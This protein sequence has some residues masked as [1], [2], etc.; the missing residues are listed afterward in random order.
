[1]ARTRLFRGWTALATKALAALLLLQL[2]FAGPG[3]VAA[4]GQGW[5]VCHV[6]RSGGAPAP[7]QAPHLCAFCPCLHIVEAAPPAL[8]SADA[9]LPFAE[10]AASRPPSATAPLTPAGRAGAWSSR[11]P[12]HA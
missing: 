12:P 3:A 6:E 5:S 7:S 2:A 8:G 11:A 1:M 10:I 9:P 4:Q